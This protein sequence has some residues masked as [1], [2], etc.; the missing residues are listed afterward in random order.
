M[1]DLG[2]ELAAGAALD[3]AQRVLVDIACRYGRPEVIAS[4]A[5]ATASTRASTGISV[6]PRPGG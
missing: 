5:S 6:P 4:N 3:L 2:V 1:R